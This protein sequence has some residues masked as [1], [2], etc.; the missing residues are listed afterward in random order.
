MKN[1]FTLLFTVF[2]FSSS[3]IA[4]DKVFTMEEAILGLRQDLKIANISHLA[5][6][7]HH[8]AFIRA[9]NSESNPSLLKVSVPSM[10]ID[11]L[12]YLNAIN[13][14]LF[15]KDSLN[16]LPQINWIAAD[17]IYFQVGLTFYKGEHTMDTWTFH[18]LMELPDSAENILIGPHGKSIAFTKVNNLYYASNDG[19]ITQVTHENNRWIESGKA[20]S[21]F[22]FGISNGIFFSPK[23]NYIA[24]YKMDETKVNDYPIIDW[25]VVPAICNTIKYPMAGTNSQKVSVGIFNPT[26]KKVVYLKTGQPYDW[27]LTNVTWGPHEKFIYVAILNRE[28]DHLQLNKYNA[29][30]GEFVKTLFEESD[31]KYLRALHPL[32]F[33]PG[34]DNQFIWLTQRD[35]F[36]HLY[37]YNTDGKLLNKVTSGDWKVSGIEG[38]NKEKKTI[39]IETTKLSPL[40]RTIYAVNWETGNMRRLD[41]APGIHHALVNSDGTYWIDNYNNHKTPRII[42]VAST[43]GRWQENLLTA[44]NILTAYASPVVKDF[45][46]TAADGHTP[47]YARLILPT[48]FDSTKQYPVVVYLYNGPGVQLLHNSFPETGRLWYN[49]LA[50]HGYIVFTMDGRG[51]ANRGLE[52]EQVTY[53]HL[54]KYEMLDQLKGVE[55]LKAL[56]YVDDENIGVHGWSY[57]G[58]MTVSLMLRHPGVFKCGVAGG[59]VI[60]WRMYEVMYTERYMDKPQDNEKGY[61]SNSL[62]DKVKNL[63]G[64]LL[65]I[66]G[67]NDPIVVWQHSIRFVKACVDKGVQLDYFVYP[68]H[69]HNVRGKDRVHLM[70]KV[71]DYF[72]EHLKD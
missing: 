70:M 27:Y 65:V 3:L 6:I 8:N 12:F 66:H 57:G 26:T 69:P 1:I 24:F 30:S 33:I 4:Q 51:S 42:N 22:E 71:T 23:G 50:Q 54:G 21:R 32:Y 9:T 64:D 19:T 46:I 47:L 25:S 62:L 7:P 43:D 49:Y 45:T 44:E 14:Q 16:H 36:N 10:K 48:D 56:P 41:E 28:Q 61:N 72:N 59:P 63:E 5:W 67:T 39:I 18:K 13:Q 20:V 17:N 2:L 52:F 35:G 38:W 29:Q 53:R 15:G 60:D 34:H 31:P 37:R 55:Y 40:D 11:T 58:F 68:G